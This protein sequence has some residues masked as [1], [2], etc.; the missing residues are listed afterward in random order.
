MS[1]AS[2]TIGGNAG[3]FGLQSKREGEIIWE[4]LKIELP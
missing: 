4:A 2:M 1:M 3:Q